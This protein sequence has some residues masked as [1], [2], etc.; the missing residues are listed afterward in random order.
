MDTGGTDCFWLPPTLL[1][2]ASGEAT[3]TP[4]PSAPPPAPTHRQANGQR[5]DR[6]ARV[7][8]VAHR[9]VFP[10]VSFPQTIQAA[11]E[12]VAL[13]LLH[14]PPLAEGKQLLFPRARLSRLKAA[15]KVR[16]AWR[17]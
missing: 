11:S 15:Q 9:R 13:S 5:R 8:C 6:G 2:R 12:Q 3:D 10:S 16:R 7:P 1:S 17:M 4:G 14:L